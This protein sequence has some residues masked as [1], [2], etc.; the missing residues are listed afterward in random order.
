MFS[1]VYSAEMW[2]SAAFFRCAGFRPN[3]VIDRDTRRRRMAQARQ[4]RSTSGEPLMNGDPHPIVG[5][6]RFLEWMR[7]AAGKQADADVRRL[8]ETVNK[9]MDIYNYW[10]PELRYKV[11]EITDTQLSVVQRAAAWLRYN[12]DQL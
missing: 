8:R 3:E 1:E 12:Y 5:W 9:A 2:L 7:S 10:R 4:L 11:V 6:A